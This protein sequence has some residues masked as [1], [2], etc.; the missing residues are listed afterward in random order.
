M[1]LDETALRE[2]PDGFHPTPCG[3]SSKIEHDEMAANWAQD[4]QKSMERWWF[5]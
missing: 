5:A 1:T 2:P 3:P 4:G